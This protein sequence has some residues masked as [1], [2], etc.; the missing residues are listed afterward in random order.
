MFDYHIHSSYSADANTSPREIIQSALQLGLNE[1]C[2]T[3]HIDYGFISLYT[4]TP[5]M[6]D[7]IPYFE[8][9][10]QLKE[11]Y[12]GRII[13]KTGLE[14]GVQPTV[15]KHCQKLINTHSF[16]Y[17]LASVHNVSSLDLTGEA[18]A[19]KYSP[20]ELWAHYFQEM[21]DCLQNLS[22]YQAVG[23]FDVPKRYNPNYAACDL[24]PLYPLVRE[25]FTHLIQEGKGIE[26]N[27]GGLLHGLPHANPSPDLLRIYRKCGGEI[28]TFGSDSH[29]PQSLGHKFKE[30]VRLLQDLNFKYLCTFDQGKPRFHKLEKLI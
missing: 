6:F 5:F 9:L 24:E 15:L 20:A 4:G 17:V 19:E 11:E 21:L 1:I 7:L 25:I 22:G 2:F 29:R 23:H 8:E 18:L 28:I 16:D 12:R 27:S 26:I 30:T 10:S 3:D 14:L 13:I